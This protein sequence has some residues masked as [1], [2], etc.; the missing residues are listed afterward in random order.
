MAVDY[1][2]NGN[3]DGTNFGQTSSSKI[4]FYGL[5][6]PIAQQTIVAITTATANAAEIQVAFDALVVQLKA[7]GLFA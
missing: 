6:A 2:D 3:D 1:I 4:G 7:T 5:T